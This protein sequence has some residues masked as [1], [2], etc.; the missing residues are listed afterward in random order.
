MAEELYTPEEVATK[1]KLSKYTIY[2]MIKRGD[3]QAHRIGR[4]LRISAK[5]L[6]EYLNPDTST[7]QAVNTFDALLLQ[8]DTGTNAKLAGSEVLFHVSTALNGPVQV[9]IEPENIIISQTQLICSARN[10]H[11]GTVSSII[12]QEN[13]CMVILD[14]GVPLYIALTPYS[15]QEMCIKPG[16]TLY[17]IFKSMSVKV[18]GR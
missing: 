13:R 14:I 2:E 12:Q 9:C 18:T 7:R 17:A 5:Q 11:K 3:L 6:E 16:D 10:V 1:L 15:V 4:G 8:T